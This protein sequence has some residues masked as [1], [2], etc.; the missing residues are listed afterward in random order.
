MCDKL[1]G[2][3]LGFLYQVVLSVLRFATHV[4][5]RSLRSGLNIGSAAC[6]DA[7]T[8]PT[9]MFC[10]MASHAF[11]KIALHYLYAEVRNRIYL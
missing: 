1:I 2:F 3:N 9:P 8:R 10:G 4:P 5:G 6:A 11:K 7:R